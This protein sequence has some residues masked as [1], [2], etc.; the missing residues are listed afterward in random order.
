MADGRL[1]LFFFFFFFKLQL[2]LNTAAF[3]FIHLQH[4]TCQGYLLMIYCNN[5]FCIFKWLTVNNE[6]YSVPH[7]VVQTIIKAKVA[8]IIAVVLNMTLLEVNSHL[9]F[10]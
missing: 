5:I 1:P 6:F 2:L 10:E 3:L 8:Y 7:A 9:V 4:P